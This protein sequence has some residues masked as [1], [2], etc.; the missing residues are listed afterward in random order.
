MKEK[1]C[2]VLLHISSLP[3]KYGIGTLGKNAFRFVDFLSETG[4]SYWEILPLESTG[5]G[6]SP[7]DIPSAYSL[8]Y[9]LIDLE[10]LVEEG[11]LSSRDFQDLEFGNNPRK[12]DFKKLKAFKTKVL[13][14][15]FKR[16]DKENQEFQNFKGN[17]FRY[18]YALFQ[19]IKELNEGKPWFDFRLEDRYFDNEVSKEVEAK[20]S[21]LIDYYLF[22]SFIFVKQWNKLHSYAR[23]KGIDIIGEIPHFLS[24]DS[25]AMYI[26]PELFLIDKRNIPIY[27]VGFPPDNFR[28]EG[29]KWG[30]PLFDW[31]Y[32]EMSNYKW[33]RY[34]LD[35]AKLFYDRIKLNH[36]RGFYKIY[37]VNFR[38]KNGK[39]G[40]YLKGPGI[41][42]IN[43]IK[44]EYPLIANDLGIYSEDVNEF[45]RE[46]GLPSIRTIFENFFATKY[47][48]ESFLP[49]NIGENTYLYLGNHDNLPMKGLIESLNEEENKIG[50]ERIFSEAKKLNLKVPRPLSL[51]E[52]T[53]FMF[54][55]AFASKAKHVSLTMQDILFHGKEARMNEPGTVNDNNWS[56]RFLWHDLNDDIKRD[57]K[58]LIRKY[59][60]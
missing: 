8:N 29:Q 37:A 22:L 9:L 59:N 24:Y 16:Y 28:K 18:Q 17:Q 10:D 50:E 56:Y 49:S 53:R 43:D 35:L 46:T 7:Y 5:M 23:S 44:K 21:N 36:F 31:H 4:F 41:N 34:R 6:N 25:D 40:I 58:E 12:V 51:F 48:S 15:A 38:S 3:G 33:W 42:F 39:K 57:L 2:G 30:Y 14:I 26:T 45:V 27:V 55:L 20:Y 52:K 60:R 47:F 19:T 32:M 1:E 13:K 54:E 11:L